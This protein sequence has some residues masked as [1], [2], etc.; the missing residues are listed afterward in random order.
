MPK[1]LSEKTGTVVAVNISTEKGTVKHPVPRIVL[2]AAGIRGDA[3]AGSWH[4]QISLLAQE[5]VEEFNK[6]SPTGRKITSGEFAENILTRGLDL[7]EFA[8]LDRLMIGAVELE[9]TQIGKKCHGD[10]CAIYREVGSCVM[11]HEGIFT[12]VIR[13]GEV[14]PG[15][16][17]RFM[18]RPLKIRV[19][20][21][22]DRASRGEYQDQSGPAVV[23]ELKAFFACKRWHAEIEAEILPDDETLLEEA[24]R[25]AAAA[26]TAF[27]F[28]TGGTGI[29]PRDITPEV[30]TRMADK[31]VPGVMEGIRVKYGL[32]KPNAL[33]SRSVAAVSG[34]TVIF[35]LPG[36][37]K[38]VQ[39][40]LSELT[41]IMEHMLFML[42]RFDTH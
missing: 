41:K 17:I 13:G 22:S 32:E 36:S 21:L 20:T 14:R 30:V 7:R 26:K 2:D 11:P 19:L 25:A 27:V 18:P 23:E 24:L 38:A 39:E 5:S 15:D 29:G 4:R 8:P 34:E 31:I 28:T 1:P 40:Y 16:A 12:R 33:L 6:L 3:H 35:T 37:V 10:S 9:V 42:H